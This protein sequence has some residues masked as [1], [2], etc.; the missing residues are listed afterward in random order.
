MSASRPE[1]KIEFD[2]D[3]PESWKRIAHVTVPPERMEAM[4]VE[5]TQKLQKK[6]RMDGFRPGK[7]PL[8]VIR[9]QWAAQVE[10]DALEGLIPEV[11]REVLEGQD[12]LHPVGEPSVENLQI[13]EGHPVRFDLVIEIRPE[14]VLEGLD[15]IEATRYL[16]PVSN[17]QVEKALEDLRNRHAHWHTLDSGGALEGD[18]LL[19]D[20]VPLAEGGEPVLGERVEGYA[21]ELGSEGVLPEFNASLEG[22]QSGEDTTVEVHYPVDFPNEDLRGTI[23]RIHVTV[24]EIRRKQLH[25]L[26]DAFAKEHSRFEGVEALRADVRRQLERG[27]RRESDRHLRE[28]LIDQIL[29][30]N[31]VPVPPSLEARYLQAMVR[32]MEQSAGEELDDERREKLAEAYRPMARRAVQRLIVLDNARRHEG[33]EI[34]DARVQSRLEELSVE[35]SVPLEELRG[36]LDRSGNLERLRNEMEEAAVFDFLEQKARVTVETELPEAASREQGAGL[37][38]D[39][40]EE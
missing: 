32:D 14:V 37:K 29:K 27:M 26:D 34:D 18:A 31:E 35:R 21:L 13:D 20:Y 11:Y 38:A 25:E 10:Q 24:K 15:R 39:A 5:V 8:R 1:D 12:D 23:R 3:A 6:A 9:R 16:P 17:E 36:A 22:L 40:S 7:V 33:I 19:I 4:R 28:Q 30:V 2:L